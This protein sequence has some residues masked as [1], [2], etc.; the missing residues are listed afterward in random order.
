MRAVAVLVVLAGVAHADAGWRYEVTADASAR[1]LR[2]EATLAAGASE[3]LS[4]DDGAEPFVRDVE[5]EEGGR[6]TR[7]AP[8]NDSWFVRACHTRGCRL[9]YRFQ[10]GAAA[11]K[12]DNENAQR[13]GELTQAPPSTWLLHPLNPPRGV[14]YRFHVTAPGGFASGVHRAGDAYEADAN[15]LPDA[16]YAVFGPLRTRTL[17]VKGGTVELAFAP[18]PERTLTDEQIVAWLTRGAR[19]VEHYY[20][21]FPVERALVVVL[22]SRGRGAHGRTMG[23]GGATLLLFVGD[24]MDAGAVR[25]DWVVT[26]ELTH[27]AFPTLP[28]SQLWMA[29]G[30]ATYIEPVA[31]AQV[32]ELSAEKVWGDEV[33]GLPQGQP[34]PGDRGL[35]HT[36]TWGRTYWGG[37]LWC[38]VADVEIRARTGN[39]RGLRDAMRAIL[40][41]GGSLARAMP[42]DEALAIGDR[43]VGV[44]VLV[45]LHAR[46]GSRPDKIDLDAM[47]RRLGVRRSDGKVSFDDSAPDA[48]IRRAI[49]AP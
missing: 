3:E 42:L 34:E 15:T 19:A 14:T 35:D 39:K 43:A 18:A 20:D 41:A 5:V 40:A 29:E 45:P 47:W 36:H 48:A 44:D 6:W 4:V 38:L 25:D 49:T 22:P 46:L 28:Q 31:R 33:E 26:H 11:D 37:A 12:L 17:A 32:G 1:E 27:L 21:R 30:L 2:V 9:R 10:L 7:V 23:S 8:R 24:R 16:P 13:F